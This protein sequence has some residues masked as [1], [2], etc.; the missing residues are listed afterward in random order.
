MNLSHLHFKKHSKRQ[1]FLF[2]TKIV[3]N[4]QFNEFY[5]I[6]VWKWLKW[7]KLQ[8]DNEQSQLQT[9]E[10]FQFDCFEWKLFIL[11]WNFQLMNFI[12]H[13]I[14]SFKLRN[15]IESSSKWI[16][17]INLIEIFFS[18]NWEDNLLSNVLSIS[19]KWLLFHHWVFLSISFLDKSFE[20]KVF[21]ELE[22]SISIQILKER[23]LES[24]LAI[25]LL[26]KRIVY[27]ITF[28]N[29]MEDL[30]LDESKI[31]ITLIKQFML[32]E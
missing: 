13:L 16:S 9:S 17:I 3:R 6:S 31:S 4:N 32:N 24:V 5:Q 23:F 20:W 21:V 30:I 2:L 29:L 7:W 14:D 18:F 19:M 12:F 26:N 27:S 11:N 10:S 22:I 8:F 15:S 28:W 25:D 1:K